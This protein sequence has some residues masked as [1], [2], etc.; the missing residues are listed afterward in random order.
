MGSFII[1]KLFNDQIRVYL[2]VSDSSSYRN[3]TLR[4][5][6]MGDNY[7]VLRP[8]LHWQTSCYYELH[9]Y[10]II[11]RMLGVLQLTERYEAITWSRTRISTVTR[12]YLGSPANHYN[13]VSS[14][15]VQYIWR[16]RYELEWRIGMRG[17]CFVLSTPYQH[18]SRGTNGTS[19]RYIYNFVTYV[20]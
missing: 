1:K 20:I 7:L 2:T 16:I 17:C 10:Y 11:Q 13:R 18:S 15:A 8:E 12:H 5:W 6:R 9:G 14:F 19:R 3:T 4:K